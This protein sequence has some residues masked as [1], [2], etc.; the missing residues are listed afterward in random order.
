M[1]RLPVAMF[2]IGLGPLFAGRLLL[3][4]HTGRTTGRTRKTV[5][6]VVD[7]EPGQPAWTIASGFGAQADWYRNLEHQPKATIQLGRRYHPVTARFLTPEEGAGVMVRYARAHP[8]LARRLSTAM[9]FPTDGSPESYRR[10]GRELP[11]VRLERQL[12]PADAEAR[13]SA[14]RPKRS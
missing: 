2:R 13:P 14:R 10:V 6:E 11:F 9:G 5:L 4:I 3:L 12:P 7:R 8:L 1:S